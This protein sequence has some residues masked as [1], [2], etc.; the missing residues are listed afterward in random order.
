MAT[1]LSNQITILQWNCNGVSSR[2]AEL[3]NY[4]SHNN[5]T[6]ICL[7]ETRLT[8]KKQFKLANYTIIRKDRPTPPPAIG[9]GT[10]IAV[11]NN[12]PFIQIPIPDNL[13]HTAISLLT[14]DPISS[15]HNIFLHIFNIYLTPQNEDLQAIKFLETT[16]ADSNNKSILV[17]DFNAYSILFNANKNNKNGHIVNDLI[18]K[19]QLCLVNT[20]HPTHI[21]NNSSE[22]SLLDLTIVTT[23]LLLNTE[24]NVL[25]DSMGSDHLPITIK[26]NQ[27]TFYDPNDIDKFNIRKADWEK[28]KSTIN[29]AFNI[30]N[31]ETSIENKYKY[32]IDELN[33]AAELSIP[34][35]K[36]KQKNLKVPYWSDKCED[37]IKKRKKSLANS[38]KTKTIDSLIDYKKHKAEAQKTIRTEQKTY[39]QNYCNTLT[40]NSKLGSVWK[41][42]KTM[43]GNRSYTIMPNLKSENTLAISNI[44][45]VE[46]MAKHFASISKEKN[47]SKTFIRKKHKFER[48][49]LQTE[50]QIYK[51]NDYLNDTFAKHELIAAIRSSKSS[52]APGADNIY[53]DFIKHLPNSA[54]AYLLQ[55]YN[56]IWLEKTNITEWKNSIIIPILKA[57]EDPTKPI[58]YRPIALTSVLSKI[59]ERMVT[60]RLTYYLDKENLLNPNQTGF[61]KHRNTV[62]Q[63]IRLHDDSFKAIHTKSYTR[64]IFLDFSKAFDMLWK[65]GLLFKLRKLKLHGNIYNYI[66]NFLTDRTI[67]VRIGNSISTPYKIANGVPQGSVISPLLFILFM[68]DFPTLNNSNIQTS[69]FADDSAIWKSGRNIKFITIQLQNQLDNIAKWCDKWGLKI[70]TKKTQ[71]LIITHKNLK[72]KDTPLLHLQKQELK[73][74]D[75]AKFLGLTFDKRLNW[76]THIENI[77]KKTT[78]ALNLLRSIVSHTWGASKTVLLTLYKSLVRSRISYGSELF[79]SATKQHLEKLDTIQYKALKIVC[80]AA[81]STSLLALQNECGDPPLY[82]QRLK[83][84]ARHI[85][86]LQIVKDNPAQNVAEDSWENYYL[87]SDSPT[88]FKQLENFLPDIAK[89]NDKSILP[90]TPPWQYTP[91]FTDTHLSTKIDKQTTNSLAAKAITLKYYE[92]YDQY[93]PIYTDG[94]KQTNCATGLGIYIPSTNTQIV[95]ALHPTYS[96]FEAEMAAIKTALTYIK[97]QFISNYNSNI[98]NSTENNIVIYSDSLSAITAIENFSTRQL[99]RQIVEILDEH[100]ILKSLQVNITIAWIPSHVDIR[101]NEM[102][103]K[104]A[105]AATLLSAEHL[106]PLVTL[107]DIY[108]TIDT[109]II[110]L[111]Q[112]VYTKSNTIPHYK[113]IEPQV[114][115]SN[116]FS[117]KNVNKESIISRLR[118]GN[119]YLNKY[120]QKI[121]KHSNGNCDH[122]LNKKE[123][124]SHFLTKCPYYNITKNITN[125]TLQSI[126]TDQIQIELIYQEIIKLNKH[127]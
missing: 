2:I 20:K 77:I 49:H 3:K 105:K 55:I 95:E 97:K 60:N 26:L 54:T 86:R 84:L 28:F 101:G 83:T 68:N 22:L 110:S 57:G 39:W 27:P 62:N 16:L 10:L 121:G 9:G 48:Q 92:I 94:S 78:P 23:N 53:Y 116:K 103:D 11:R 1:T 32:F 15:T 51:E 102:A 45:K 73:I 29:L 72:T 85:T 88:I 44:E 90:N 114:N 38:R 43:S 4:I 125:P 81:H 35:T 70:N 67:Q 63:L 18:E 64:A 82:I 115:F 33:K 113:T 25:D 112:E 36:N 12:I 59:L 24:Y 100:A 13:E 17:G 124:I 21:K 122:C 74:V 5:P 56:Q 34:K 40:E 108:K 91:I 89:F 58:S 96:I 93:F 71:D 30:P 106:Q 123:T 8:K 66:T 65:E 80:K 14:N 99:T 41:M 76:K 104:L 87:T 37:A 46:V 117:S 61:R 111:W 109:K 120:L 98:S 6:I 127:L 126:L 69:L 107:I 47:Y 119:T 75:S 7:Q 118:L 79:Y 19:N 50:P 31:Q 52:S 42:A